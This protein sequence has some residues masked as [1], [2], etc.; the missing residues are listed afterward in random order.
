MSNFNGFQ[1]ANSFIYVNLRSSVKLLNGS[2][3][4]QNSSAFVN[5]GNFVLWG[6]VFVLQYVFVKEATL[7]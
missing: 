1:A 2:S 3:V 7:A 4:D 6:L 5:A